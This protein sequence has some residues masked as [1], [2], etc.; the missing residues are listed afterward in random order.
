MTLEKRHAVNSALVPLVFGAC[1]PLSLGGEAWRFGGLRAG[2]AVVAGCGAGL[3]Q[4]FG[5]VV[6]GGLEFTGGG[7]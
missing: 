5:V 7:F 1:Q 4:Y 6:R 2:F 3:T